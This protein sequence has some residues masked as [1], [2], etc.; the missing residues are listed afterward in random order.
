ML[1]IVVSGSYTQ[2]GNKDCFSCYFSL[3]FSQADK[4][5]IF[6]YFTVAIYVFIGEKVLRAVRVVKIV[7]FFQEHSSIIC[8]LG[9]VIILL[10]YLSV[11]FKSNLLYLVL[12]MIVPLCCSSS[13]SNGRLF[14]GR[15]YKQ[16]LGK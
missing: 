11:T 3:H 5:Y 2:N 6:N 12:Q 10:R 15:F 9:F 1:K 7:F 16:N 13:P 4:S 8:F 14:K